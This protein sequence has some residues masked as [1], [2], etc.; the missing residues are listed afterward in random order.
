MFNERL[1]DHCEDKGDARIEAAYRRGCHQTAVWLS[2]AVAE[3]QTLAA[4]IQIVKGAEERL[5]TARR[6]KKKTPCYLHQVLWNP[7]HA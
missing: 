2:A 3:C 1:H 4:A 5:S 6:S 7:A